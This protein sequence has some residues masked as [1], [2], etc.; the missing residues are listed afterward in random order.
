MGWW[1]KDEAAGRV[2]AAAS[3]AQRG[4]DTAR[5]VREEKLP[6]PARGAVQMQELQRVFQAREQESRAVSTGRE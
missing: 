1:L 2:R 4:C 6:A 5:P 3:T